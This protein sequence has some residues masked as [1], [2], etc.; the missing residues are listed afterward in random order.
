MG[1][2]IKVFENK[3]FGTIRAIEVDGQPWFVGK[4]ITAILG[5]GKAR[6]ALTA[7]VDEDD[8]LKWGVTDSLGRT[9][10]TTVINESGLYSLILSS[11]LPTAK[12][13]KRWVTAEVL[14]SLRQHGAYI[15]EEILQEMREDTD[16]TDRLLERLAAEQAKNGA[17]LDF[18]N[19]AAPKVRYYDSVLQSNSAIQASIIAKDYGM[20]A[21]AFNNLLHSLGIQYKIGRTW[22]L[23]SS[24]T[25]KGYTFSKT[26]TV[27]GLQ[28]A[29]FTCW[30]E[31]GRKWLYDVLKWYGISPLSERKQEKA[32]KGCDCP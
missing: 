9:Q 28:T 14:P 15:T 18:V 20:S 23:Y 7:H 21:A 4:D 29:I 3:D 12:A 16:F 27:D 2:Q 5:Y 24:F 19:R 22:L 10:Q 11:K 31:K 8:A 6:N 1:N 26:K 30:T 25:N 13:F 17:L 32:M